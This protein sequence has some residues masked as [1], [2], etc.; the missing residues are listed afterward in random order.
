MRHNIGTTRLEK[1]GE[2]LRI[3]KSE[4]GVTHGY[5]NSTSILY[6]QKLAGGATATDD[7]VDAQY[8][9]PGKCCDLFM[10]ALS[11]PLGLVADLTSEIAVNAA[12]ISSELKIAMADSIILATT[13]AYGAT[14]WTQDAD[15]EGIDSVQYIR[16]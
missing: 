5:A 2:I 1:H 13:Q 8:R 10:M 11:R 4:Y 16:K 3:L 9:E 15:F 6:R 14:L 7:L 12:T